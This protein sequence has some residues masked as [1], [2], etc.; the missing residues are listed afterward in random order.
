MMQITSMNNSAALLGKKRQRK[1][2]RTI[3]IFENANHLMK[4]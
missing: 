3:D 4:R 1:L 2:K